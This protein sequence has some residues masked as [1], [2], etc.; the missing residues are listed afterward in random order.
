MSV[1][2]IHFL[3]LASVGGLADV[4]P[5]FV[6]KHVRTVDWSD[7]WVKLCEVMDNLRSSLLDAIVEPV[8]GN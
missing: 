3:E 5:D 6:H 4:V 8:S 2:Q 1:S 7:F